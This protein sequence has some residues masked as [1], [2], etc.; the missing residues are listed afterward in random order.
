LKNVRIQDLTPGRFLVVEP[1]VPQRLAWAVRERGATWV[2]L[3]GR[4]YRLAD[5]SATRTVSAAGDDAAL[6]LSAPMPATV[7]AVHVA[8]GQPVK[9]GDTLITLEAM[10]MELPIVAPHDGV[11]RTIAC[12]VGD[13]VQPGIPLAAIDR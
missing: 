2:F 5:E 6:A 9:A 8:P 3:D 12:G 4:A 11:I 10:K 7:T 13:L 1:G